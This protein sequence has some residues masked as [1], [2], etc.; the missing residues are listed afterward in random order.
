[1]TVRA[2]DSQRKEKGWLQRLLGPTGY[3]KVPIIE[4][5]TVEDFEKLTG[6]DGS[7]SV[8]MASMTYCGPCK[9]MD[10]K[11]QLFAEAYPNINFIKVTGDKNE[12]TRQILNKIRVSAVPAFR[13]FKDGKDVSGE[14]SVMEQ[15]NVSQA[16]KTLR[17]VIQRNL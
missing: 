15:M 11:F 14:L 9:L 7:L 1:V 8:V 6:A 16:E 4:V 5:E 12:D 3:E 10:P 17:S 13:V 2:Q